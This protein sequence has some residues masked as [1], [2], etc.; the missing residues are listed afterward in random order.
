MRL[1]VVLRSLGVAAALFGGSVVSGGIGTLLPTTPAFAQSAS[2]I[3]VQGNRRVDA[4][5]I[6]SYFR[7]S[8]GQ[9]LDAV[10][11]DE[12]YKALLATGLF[13]DV[14]ISQSGGRI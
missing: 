3:V 5:T 7:P 2:N 12:A 6:R 13:E 8:P 4:D 14:R 1:W 11:I 10:R 9:R